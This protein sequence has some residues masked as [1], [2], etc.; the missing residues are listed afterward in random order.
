MSAI[1]M[2][3]TICSRVTRSF[4]TSSRTL[5]GSNFLIITWRAPA[6]VAT[7]GVPQLF[8]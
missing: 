1:S 4:W 5:T 6:R 8:T 7:C 3:G 2:V